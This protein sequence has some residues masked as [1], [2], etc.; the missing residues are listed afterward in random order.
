MVHGNNHAKQIVIDQATG[1]ANKLQNGSAGC[2]ETQGKA[3]GLLVQMVTPLYEADF[4]TVQECKENRA[5]SNTEKKTTKIKLGP[6]EI[7]G[8]LT[9]TAILQCMPI[10]CCGIIIFMVVKVQNWW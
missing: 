9:T 7:E 8:P 4:I 6:I 5:K 10:V 2:T 1:L 3:I